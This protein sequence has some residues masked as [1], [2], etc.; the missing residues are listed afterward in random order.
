MATVPNLAMQQAKDTVQ[1]KMEDFHKTFTKLPN[2]VGMTV[3]KMILDTL[4]FGMA[5][6]SS[7]GWNMCESIQQPGW[8]L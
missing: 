6:A 2:K 1:A 4:T 8:L 3:A 5:G 7:Y